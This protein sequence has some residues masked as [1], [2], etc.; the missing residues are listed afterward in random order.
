MTTVNPHWDVTDQPS[1]TPAPASAA[2]P[3]TLGQTM[4]MAVPRGSPRPAAILGVLLAVMVGVWSTLGDSWPLTGQAANSAV[5][6]VSKTGFS[7]VPLEVRIGEMV[8]IRNSDS[9]AHTIQI[10]NPVANAEPLYSITLQPRRAGMMTVTDDMPVGTYTLTTTDAIPFIGQ[11]MISPGVGG[12]ITSSSSSS[13]FS[14]ARP[15]APLAPATT[16]ATGSDDTT[17]FVI[18]VNPYTVGSDFRTSAAPATDVVTTTTVMP[19]GMTNDS[20]YRAAT[21]TQ[22][23]HTSPPA[24]PQSGPEVWVIVASA[25]AGF[26]MLARRT[27]RFD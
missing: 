21:T 3:R 22:V 11:V 2:A 16:P 10:V 14:P 12:S 17:P 13:R 15:S 25:L 1:S 5:L 18:E 26:W 4:P 27:W 6:V 9:V 24:I 8:A 19:V 20:N 7:P 23:T